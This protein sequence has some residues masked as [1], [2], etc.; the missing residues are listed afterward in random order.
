MVMRSGIDEARFP[1]YAHVERERRWLVDPVR[2]PVLT[3]QP[4]VLIEDRYLIDTRLRLR[5]MTD[6]ISREQSLKLTKKYEAGDPLARPI[7]TTY[8]TE[9]EFGVFAM[10]PSFALSKRRYEVAVSGLVFSIDMFLDHLAGL[11]LAEIEWPDDDGLRRL[12]DPA[13]AIREISSDV[14][15]QG[16]NLAANGLPK[17]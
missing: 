5:R 10:L 6:S 4:F 16:G 1:K 12:P 13:W 8:L 15:Y 7:V 14:R 17:D 11:E 2:R 3:E 9:A